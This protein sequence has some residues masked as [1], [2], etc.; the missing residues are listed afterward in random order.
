MKLLSSIHPMLVYSIPPKPLSPR[1]YFYHAQQ[2]DT[3]HFSAA[4]IALQPV[5]RQLTERFQDTVEALL[6]VPETGDYALPVSRSLLS[7]MFSNADYVLQAGGTEDEA[8]A[9]MRVA[10]RRE[11]SN[12]HPIEVFSQEDD[13]HVAMWVEQATTLL[14]PG[15]AWPETLSPE[16]QRIVWADLLSMVRN[17]ILEQYGPK[18][19]TS[20]KN[21]HTPDPLREIRPLIQQFNAHSTFAPLRKELDQE[22]HHLE[23]L[24]L[25]PRSRNGQPTVI[26]PNLVLTPRFFEVMRWAFE[27]HHTQ[28]RKI[29]KE[30]YAAHLLGVTSLLIAQGANEEAV[31][32]GFLHDGPE[33][34]GGER[35]LQ[36]IRRRFPNPGDPNSSRVADMVSQCT[37]I[38]GNWKLR[39]RDYIDRKISDPDVLQIRAA[40]KLHNVQ[41]VLSG[42][43][44]QGNRVWKHFRRN[45]Q[46]PAEVRD[47]QLWSYRSLLTPLAVQM[48]DNPLVQKAEVSLHTLEVLSGALKK[49]A[50]PDNREALG[51]EAEHYIKQVLQERPVYESIDVLAQSPPQTMPRDMD[52]EQLSTERQALQD[53]VLET[54]YQRYKTEMGPSLPN[55][56]KVA[57]IITGPFGAGKSSVIATALAR[58][59]H[60]IIVDSDEIK[61][62]FP[63]YHMDPDTPETRDLGL[64]AKNGVGAS[65][66]YNE[67]RALVMSFVNRVLDRGDNLV[68]PYIGSDLNWDKAFIQD[69]KRRGYQVFIHHIEVVPKTAVE[70]VF[71]RFD[72]EG[73]FVPL[74]FLLGIGTRST[75]NFAELRRWG[76]QTGMIDGYTWVNNEGEQPIPIESYRADPF[77]FKRP[78]G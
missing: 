54:L 60:A 32:A 11:I 53:R 2:P 12:Q 55:T 52:L 44:Q 3:V 26:S 59:D 35:I 69:L 56:P 36:E 19:N 10:H 16:M 57:H 40:D 71:R 76:L 4:A 20:Q 75:D 18:R 49:R 28:Q 14:T 63:E 38:R 9:A 68:I 33:D 74:K 67:S 65:S 30:P 6:H 15:S 8:I 51:E 29:F 48:P 45:H 72:T 58:Q 25:T 37:E 5:S 43:Y 46:T 41:S 7:H 31:M 39:R 22:F 50:C 70:R 62:G 77:T 17:A 27:L 1:G 73:R 23:Q 21:G 66:L 24:V 64:T 47:R 78:E 34:Q 42:F 13:P 61:Q